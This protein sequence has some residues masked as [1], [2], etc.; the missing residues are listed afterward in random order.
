MRQ[1]GVI[2]AA[3]LEALIN[4][5]VRLREV[6]TQRTHTRLRDARF[7][8]MLCARNRE[9]WLWLSGQL[10]NYVTV[11]SSCTL[12]LVKSRIDRQ[13]NCRGGCKGETVF[14]TPTAPFSSGR[15]S[16]EHSGVRLT[17]WMICRI[18]IRFDRNVFFLVKRCL[19]ETGPQQL[20]KTNLCGTRRTNRSKPHVSI[21][22]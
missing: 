3:G 10:C 15:I 12:Q 4:N 17:G 16:L 11:F 22:D 5:Y 2:A 20:L 8:C 9:A 19:R 14:G 1:A 7:C 21:H 18:L 13:G 6:S